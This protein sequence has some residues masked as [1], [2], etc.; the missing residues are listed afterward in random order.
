[1]FALLLLGAA[2]PA[3][4]PSFA[5][6]GTLTSTEKVICTDPE[7]AAWDRS[8][9]KVYRVQ[10]RDGGV[11]F[12]DQRRWIADR[13]RCGADRAC[14]LK[15]HREWL[16]WQ[17]EAAGFGTLYI[18]EKTEPRDPASLE[19]LQIFDGW[20]FYSLSALH[21]QNAPDGINDGQSWGLV[22]LR[23]GKATVTNAPGK[24]Y[25]CRFKLE[26][27]KN[28]WA[29]EEFGQTAGCG[30]LNVFLSGEYRLSTHSR[31]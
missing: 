30:G 21:V 26:K 17:S 24:D 7:L 1:M 5:C 6:I 20:L 19:I 22:R 31:H 9:A 29:I 12:V 8:V 16:G 4:R 23:N 13:N 18:R 3:D 28:G 11:S 10:T 15:V 27:I 2:A 14:L 25:G